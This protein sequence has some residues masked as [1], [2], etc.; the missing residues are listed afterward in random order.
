MLSELITL[1][2]DNRS[3]KD[4]LAI[5][6]LC[7]TTGINQSAAYRVNSRAYSYK[8]YLS[9]LQVN[10]SFHTRRVISATCARVYDPK[11]PAKIR[12]LEN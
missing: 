8:G 2:E 12:G 6:H 1:L 9:C 11:G 4:T 5:C 10:L 3:A 7:Q